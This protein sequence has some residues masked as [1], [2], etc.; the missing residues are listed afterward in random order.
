MREPIWIETERPLCVPTSY[1]AHDYDPNAQTY[2]DLQSMYLL[3]Q[4][5]YMAGFAQSTHTHCLTQEGACAQ[6][7][8]SYE[9]LQSVH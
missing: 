8:K 3:C 7:L 6:A 4:S 9:D 1:A 5:L 2:A